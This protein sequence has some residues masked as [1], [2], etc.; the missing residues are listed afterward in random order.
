[1][2]II[3]DTFWRC[4]GYAAVLALFLAASL[5]SLRSKHSGDVEEK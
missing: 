3:P 4:V 1:M 2:K 5:V